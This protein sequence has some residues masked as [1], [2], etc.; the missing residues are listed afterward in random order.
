MYPTPSPLIV[1]LRASHPA[2]G[3]RLDFCNTYHPWLQGEA[4]RYTGYF[5]PAA[6]GRPA[7]P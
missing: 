1:F 3:E 7:P 6:P 4:E 2:L 5:K